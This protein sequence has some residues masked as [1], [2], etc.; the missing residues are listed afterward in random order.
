[1]KVRQL[2]KWQKYSTR[3]AKIGPCNICGCTS[4]LSEDHIPPKGAIRVT[5]VEIHHLAQTLGVDRPPDRGRLS[6]D[7]VKFRTLCPDC[8]NNRL[9]AK[10][11]P[12]LIQFTNAV[13]LA[14][15]ATALPLSISVPV[16]PQRL[17]R[18]VIGHLLAFGIRQ[19][20]GPFEN[21]MAAYFL[22]ESLSLPAD[23]KLYYWL[24][25]YRQRILIRDCAL[26]HLAAQAPVVIKV[27]KYFPLGFLLSWQQ[28]PQY[29]F[30][31]NDLS[32]FGHTSIDA[33]HD[34]VVDLNTRT[35]Q[36]F[37]EAPLIKEV[38]VMY[39]Q[40]AL[41]AT[42]YTRSVPALTGQPV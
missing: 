4:V 21:A 11:D 24:Y 30:Q 9:G 27:M 32:R 8:N 36:L 28:P 16:V 1:M 19:P 25:P 12:A 20:S 39:G 22:D 5:Q 10:F 34:A 26:I 18:A 2:A 41:S 3:G 40:E 31:L 17:M 13:T 14:L 35:P 7:G 23:V 6:Q 38:L 42:E 15:N 29:S 37:P 33:V